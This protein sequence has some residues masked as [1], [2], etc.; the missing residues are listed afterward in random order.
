MA[1][2]KTPATLVQVDYVC[3]DCSKG[4]MQETQAQPHHAAGDQTW[5]L[6]THCGHGRWLDKS[7]PYT[8]AHTTVPVLHGHVSR[9]P[10]A[11][12]C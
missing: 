2:T 8:E 3:D 7:Y 10:E 9:D 6:C 11:V 5:H 1:E 12:C 4:T